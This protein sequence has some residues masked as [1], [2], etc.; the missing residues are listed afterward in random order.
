ML[1]THRLRMT[2]ALEIQ[3]SATI[4]QDILKRRIYSYHGEVR[5]DVFQFIEM[6]HN[7][8]RRLASEAR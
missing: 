6:F 7:R 4:V 1:C 2:P 8:K 5:G 3:G